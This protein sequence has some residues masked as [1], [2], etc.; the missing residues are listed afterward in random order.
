MIISHNEK[1]KSPF[2]GT[3]IDFE[4]IGDFSDYEDCDSRRYSKLT[5][6]IM[7]Y[8]TKDELTIL[9]AKGMDALDEL[10]E[11]AVSILPSLKKPLFAFQSRFERGVFHHSYGIRVEFDGELNNRPREGK[12]YACSE[13]DIPNYDDPFNNVGKDCS[14]AWTKGN[15]SDAIKHNRSCLLQER[16]I[17]L[18][19]R[20]RAPDE[21]K[22]L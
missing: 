20:H 6:T 18:K 19:R 7:G 12:G 22:L 15:Y 16:D 5:P 11:Q 9:C 21:L 14:I 8:I 4:T 17:L 13:L 3:I 1:I 10:R 2:K